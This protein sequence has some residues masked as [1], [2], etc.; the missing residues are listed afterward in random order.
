MATP[1][2][3]FTTADIA[4]TARQQRDEK[5]RDKQG[6]FSSL[7]WSTSS[8]SAQSQ[9]PSQPPPQQPTSSPY[10]RTGKAS[11]ANIYEQQRTMGYTPD[12]YTTIKRGG[13]KPKTAKKT[14][15]DKKATV[16]GKSYSVYEGPR[17]GKYIKKA[18]KFV[19]L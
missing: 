10:D 18:G 14:R 8:A 4:N 16:D 11:M 9:P 17:G 6:F 15:T 7:F 13:S 1:G 3:G 12:S 19:R 5:E 2:P